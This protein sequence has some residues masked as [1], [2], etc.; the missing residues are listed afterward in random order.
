MIDVVL[1]AATLQDITCS[2]ELTDKHKY[3]EPLCVQ[4]SS[5]EWYE[6]LNHGHDKTVDRFKHSPISQP[7]MIMQTRSL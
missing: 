1:D 6:S 5:F 3:R 4:K 2:F 7:N